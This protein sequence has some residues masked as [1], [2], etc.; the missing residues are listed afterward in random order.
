MVQILSDKNGST[1]TSEL[2]DEMSRLHAEIDRLRKIIDSIKSVLGADIFENAAPV[3]SQR[4]IISHLY[5][6]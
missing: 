2:M 6:T 4:Y 1:A 3:T 5:N